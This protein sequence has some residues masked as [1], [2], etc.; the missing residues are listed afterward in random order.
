[1]PRLT[2]ALTL[3]ALTTTACATGAATHASQSELAA[4]QGTFTSTQGEDW[5]RGTYGFRT[6]TF[7]QGRWTL[8]FTLALDPQMKSR[9]FGFRTVGTYS[10]VGPS[11]ALP[12]TFEA[13]FL[14]DKKF[15][16][17]YAAEPAIAPGFGLAA[18]NL[19]VGQ[20]QDI[21]ATGCALWKPVSVCNQ[22]HDLLSLEK[23]DQLFFGVR[24]DDNDM[25]TPD[26]RPT[27]LL[28]AVVR[29]RR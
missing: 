24:P 18:C 6:F 29:A 26:K 21:S 9:V 4:L 16:T 20:E 25:C 2:L 17:L 22:D 11:K 14:E 7:D 13:L 3:A 10:L 8:D 1:M 5:G 28:P 19:T 23:P 15:V 27:R 12:D